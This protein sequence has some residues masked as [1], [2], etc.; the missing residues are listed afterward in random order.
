MVGYDLT[1][2]GNNWRVKINVPIQYTN[3]SGQVVIADG[4]VSA[5]DFNIQEIPSFKT[6]LGVFDV[7]IAGKVD[8]VAIEADLA[9]IRKLNG[10]HITAN[11]AVW[12]SNG[13]FTNVTAGTVESNVINYR[14][15]GMS[16]INILSKIYATYRF[17][18]DNGT[19]KLQ[20]TVMN[21][22]AGGYVD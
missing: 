1:S 10:D 14:V 9:Y 12:A 5:S 7:V 4:F 20:A 17:L 3:Q 8:A 16:P 13:N 22:Q 21:N 6:K 18:E 19:I 2:S 11:T 15:T